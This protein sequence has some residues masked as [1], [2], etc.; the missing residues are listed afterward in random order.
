M[1]EALS[2]A[3]T[4]GAPKASVEV[5]SQVTSA[6]LRE[7][8]AKDSRIILMTFNNNT[9]YGLDLSKVFCARHAACHMLCLLHVAP[10]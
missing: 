6:L 5:S 9:A 2:H 7:A 8:A 10:A 4:L 3:S 1:G